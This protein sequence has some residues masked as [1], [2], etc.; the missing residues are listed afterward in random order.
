[1]E[2]LHVWSSFEWECITY[3]CGTPQ[4]NL[5]CR[6]LKEGD[7]KSTGYIIVLHRQHMLHTH[8][9]IPLVFLAVWSGDLYLEVNHRCS[10]LCYQIIHLLS[11]LL[12]CTCCN[13]SDLYSY[14][15]IFNA[16]LALWLAL[17]LEKYTSC[18]LLM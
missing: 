18:M 17:A 15:I 13:G 12:L 2:M 6:C 11:T 1:M 7:T 4:L 10:G 3:G 9:L 16:V 14:P 8:H 5:V